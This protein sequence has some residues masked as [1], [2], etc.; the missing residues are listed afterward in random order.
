MTPIQSR[1]KHLM[2]GQENIFYMLIKKPLLI[3]N[4][5][6]KPSTHWMDNEA[7]ESLKNFDRKQSVEFQL[8]TP[9]LHRRNAAERA[10]RTWKN[11]LIALLCGVVKMLPIHLWCC[12]LKQLQIT[13]NLLMSA[14]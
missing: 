7:S 3:S 13:F 9:H 8:V 10:I 4:S 12:L 14:R 11:N 5:G 1:L 6:F 2:K